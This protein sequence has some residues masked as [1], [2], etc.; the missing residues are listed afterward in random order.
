MD[1]LLLP[2]AVDLSLY[3]DLKN[4]DLEAHIQRVGIVFL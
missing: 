3:D 1:D 2:Y 4:P